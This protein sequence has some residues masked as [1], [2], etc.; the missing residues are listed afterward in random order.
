M[1]EKRGKIVDL[2]LARVAAPLMRRIRELAVETKNVFLSE[3]AL[4]RM[5]ERGI[6]DLEVF[7]V[8]RLGEIRGAPWAEPS[9]ESACKV[10][11]RLQGSRTLG[12]ITILLVE[13]AI[14]VKTVEWEDRP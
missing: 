1:V 4:E 8:L 6:D 2:P 7:Q 12:V 9:G 3:H 14:F 5:W 13:G 10:V 11:F